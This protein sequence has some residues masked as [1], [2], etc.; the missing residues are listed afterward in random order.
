MNGK[1]IRQLLSGGLALLGAAGVTTV[2]AAGE[3]LSLRIGPALAN[4]VTTA[5]V[6]IRNPADVEAFSLELSFASGQTLSLP[7]T[8]WFTRGGYFPASP[9]GPAPAAELNDYIDS[10]ARTR[11]YLD[12]FHPSAGSGAVGGV[13]FKVAAGAKPK[14]DDDP[15]DAQVI[16]L[17]G[18]F[19]SRSLQ[20]EISFLAVTAEFTV[21]ASQDGDGDGIP[22]SLDNCPTVNNPDQTDSNGNGVGDACDT[23]PL[24]TDGDGIPDSIDPDDDNDGVLDASDN[25]PLVANPDQADDDRD[26]IGNACDPTPRLCRE[27][28]PGR[29]GWRAIL[30]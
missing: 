24:D 12:G 18:K 1:R 29:G 16:A 22:D 6:E 23:P 30:H 2:Q 9:F 21:A 14:I 15:A 19:W 28:L 4:G 27:C 17:S 7:T 5:V 26:G 20:R 10:I 8:G 3:A 11:V 13:T 25:C